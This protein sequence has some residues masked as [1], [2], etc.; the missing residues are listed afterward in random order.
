MLSADGRPFDEAFAGTVFAWELGNFPQGVRPLAQAFAVHGAQAQLLDLLTILHRHWGPLLAQDEG[1]ER[2]LADK[3]ADVRALAASGKL[4]ADLTQ[5]PLGLEVSP[6]QLLAGVLRAAVATAEDGPSPVALWL[7]AYALGAQAEPPAQPPG[8]SA[9][10]ALGALKLKPVLQALLQQVAAGPAQGL[11]DA[12]T[13]PSPALWLERPELQAAAKLLSAALAQPGAADAARSMWRRL[14]V[15][16]QEV[17]VTAL[18]DSLQL[19]EDLPGTAP[20]L[21]AVARHLLTADGLLPQS[22][23]VLRRLAGPQGLDGE[24][25]L[26]RLMANLFAL[27]QGSGDGAAQEAPVEALVDIFLQLSRAQVGSTAP[28]EPED[29]AASLAALRQFLADE[30]HGLMRLLTLVDGRRGTLAPLGARP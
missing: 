23:N 24:R 13:W 18:A 19:I 10:W 20:L 9:P 26:G 29:I 6:V 30:Q 4:L 17:T 27:P 14:L 11:S 2:R 7:E 5:A 16:E 25:A 15:D 12:P 22:L 28:M 21:S 8:A 1:F 3:L